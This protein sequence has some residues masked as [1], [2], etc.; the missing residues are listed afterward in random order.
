MTDHLTPAR[1]RQLFDSLGEVKAR[2]LLDKLQ[3]VALN[4]PDALRELETFLD[5]TVG[6]AAQRAS[7]S[8]L[9]KK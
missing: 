7:R 9:A 5:R 8:E 2:E 3:V 4:G 1:Y 6:K